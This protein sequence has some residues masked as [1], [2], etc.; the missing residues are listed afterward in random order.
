MAGTD[1]FSLNFVG[2]NFS[3]VGSESFCS[4]T[5]PVEVNRQWEVFSR[6]KFFWKINIVP[7]PVF[8]FPL[9]GLLEEYFKF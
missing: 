8:F 5:I 9:A 4:N 7:G 6:N 2:R 3:I 1:L